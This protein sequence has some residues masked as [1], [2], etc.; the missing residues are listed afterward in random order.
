[1]LLVI[2]P[3]SELVRASELSEASGLEDAIQYIL[4][5]VS[6]LCSSAKVAVSADKLVV[7]MKGIKLKTEAAKYLLSL[8]SIPASVAASVAAT[9]LKKGVTLD[10]EVI[11]GKNSTATFRVL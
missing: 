9:V 11:E 8:G 1:M 3:G 2:P 4:T 10:S 5:E 7:E 6:E